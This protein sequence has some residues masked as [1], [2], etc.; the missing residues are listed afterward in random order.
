VPIPAE[1][2]AERWVA[3]AHRLPAVSS[4]PPA[5]SRDKFDAIDQMTE[6]TVISRVSS[7]S[8][9][10][11]LIIETRRSSIPVCGPRR[12]RSTVN[13]RWALPLSDLPCLSDLNPTP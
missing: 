12:R 10:P 13:P 6:F 2:Q 11:P 7:A 9:P 3:E 5:S 8:P 4:H 1:K